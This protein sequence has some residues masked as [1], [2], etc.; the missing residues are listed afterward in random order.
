MSWAAWLLVGVG[1][2]VI[3]AGAGQLFWVSTFTPDPNPN[4]IGNGMLFA[5]S[6]LVGEALIGIGLVWLIRLRQ[7]KP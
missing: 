5:L 3:L 2:L 4:P 7:Q 1:V 6:C